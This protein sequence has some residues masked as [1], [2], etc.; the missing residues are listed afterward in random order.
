MR[1]RSL[2]SFFIFWFL[3]KT[4]WNREVWFM[5]LIAVFPKL[6]ITF[7]IWISCWLKHNSRIQIRFLKG[8][9]SRLQFLSYI[10]KLPWYITVTSFLIRYI[11]GMNKFNQCMKWNGRSHIKGCMFDLPFISKVFQFILVILEWNSH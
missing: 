10:F 8:Y 11:F 1:L 7:L 4:V 3:Q 6:R 2:F 9:L 5:T